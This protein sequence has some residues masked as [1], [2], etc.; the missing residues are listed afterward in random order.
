MMEIGL[1]TFCGLEDWNCAEQ[2]MQWASL[3]CLL[4]WRVF[5]TQGLVEFH[6]NHCI[7][8]VE[9]GGETPMYV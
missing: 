8:S 1:D 5:A 3:A 6:F 9:L 2:L 4:R 7:C